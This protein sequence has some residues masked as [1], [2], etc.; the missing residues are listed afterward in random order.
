MNRTIAIVVRVLLALTLAFQGGC[1][2][3]GPG[4]V[5]RD[6]SCK[7][8]EMQIR[9]IFPPREDVQ[10]GDVYW[11]QTLSKNADAEAYCAPPSDSVKDFVPFPLYLAHLREVTAKAKEQYEGRP[12]FPRSTSSAGTVTVTATGITMSYGTQSTDV[13]AG[14]D[15]LF[16]SGRPNRT[17]L[18]G[19]PDFMSV[20]IDKGS[21][22][23]I[24]P[25]QGVFTPFGLSVDDVDE[26]SISI[27]VAESYGVPMATAWQAATSGGSK[28]TLCNA[29]LFANSI[30]AAGDPPTSG[31]LHL[32]TEVYYTRAIDVSI[33][34]RSAV[35][36]GIA[37]DRA[38][39]GTTTVPTITSTAAI[40]PTPTT[41]L[42]STTV[43]DMATAAAGL[44]QIL[45]ARNSVPGVSLAWDHGQSSTINMRRVF[46][47]PVAIGY[48][49]IPFHV[50]PTSKATDCS[51]D[52]VSMQDASGAAPAASEKISNTPPPDNAAP[53]R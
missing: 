34:S 8:R 27:P 20:K 31:N 46:D 1:A 47:R 24:I 35:S 15:T 18:V 12:D 13:T 5:A 21:L 10:V 29:G 9:P 4:Q 23:A 48:R 33:Q 53:G 11:L 17:R 49:S 44:M 30:V 14:T 36:L 39:A 6:W 41:A 51:F 42:G 40:T 28:P 43:Q 50:K 3:F 37:R 52:L 45:N 25:I 26:A 7:I 19:F 38:N 16:L 2:H 22:G 32:I